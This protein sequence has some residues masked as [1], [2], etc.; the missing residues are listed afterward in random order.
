MFEPLHEAFWGD[1]T[2]QFIDPFGHRWAIDQHIR[3]VPPG[4]VA[5]LAAEA[6]GQGRAHAVHAVRRHRAPGLRAVP[7]RDDVRRAGRGRRPGTRSTARILGAYA[8]AGGNVIDT[9]INYRGGASAEIVGELLQGRRDRFV[10]STKYTVTSDPGDPNAAG[11]HRKN[12]RLSL[13]T[14]LRRLR[15]DYIDIYWVHMWNTGTPAEETM[16]ALDDQVRAGKILYAGISDV[17][18]WVVSRANALAQWRGWTAFSGLQA[19]Y[20]LLRRDI[21][22]ELLPMAETLGPHPGRLEP[23][24]RRDPVRQVRPRGHGRAAQ[25]DRPRRCLPLSACGRG[26]GP[27][28]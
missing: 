5:R 7:G 24:G 14:S 8:E 11:N 12:L 23:A 17:P 6:F 10:L 4:E 18:A 15:T 22:R 2:G 19:P 26:T 25:P 13:E 9:A 28:K 3:D 27:R 1:R 16:R 20:S 21:E